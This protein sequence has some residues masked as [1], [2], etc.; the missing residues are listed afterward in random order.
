M[1]YNGIAEL[2][3]IL[4]QSGDETFYQW[5][6]HGKD[7]EQ[8]QICEAPIWYEKKNKWYF[9]EHN[10]IHLNEPESTWYAHPFNGTLPKN[11]NSHVKKYF[12]LQDDENLI[13]THGKNRTIILVQKYNTDWINPNHKQHDI[14]KWLCLPVFSYQERHKQHYILDDQKFNTPNRIYL[15][16][17]YCDEHPGMTKECCIQLDSIQTINEKYIKPVN[18]YCNSKKM[19]YPFKITSKAL[20]IIMFH[21]IKQFNV[22]G[23]SLINDIEKQT[24]YDAFVELVRETINEKTNQI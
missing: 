3:D 23:S 13:G 4:L 9:S 2:Y 8:G 10:F 19:K 21:F 7:S 14:I 11:N 12:E 15:P 22:F 24:E 5:L 18:S 20:K 17:V 6:E 1:P 16:P